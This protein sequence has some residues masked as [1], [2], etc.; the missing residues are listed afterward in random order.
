MENASKALLMAAEILIGILV[1]SVA[2]ILITT[3]KSNLDT[4][5]EVIDSQN[6]EAFNTK[7]LKYIEIY[8]SEQYISAQNLKT[9]YKL[10]K[11]QKIEMEPPSC[12]V[13]SIDKMIFTDNVASKTYTRYYKI[14]NIEYNGPNGKISKINVDSATIYYKDGNIITKN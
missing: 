5:S 12:P 6:I 13:E 11:Q 7:F 14:N 8:N 4:Y 2:I 10:A 9:L 1:L 3:Y